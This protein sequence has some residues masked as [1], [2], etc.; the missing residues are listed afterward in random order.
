MIRAAALLLPLFLFAAPAI[1]D[2]PTVRTITT[3]GTA[4]IHVVPDEAMLRFTVHTFDADLPKSKKLNDAA[5]A[6]ILGFFRSNGI[7]AKD[8]Q[9]AAADS[10]AV[11][12]YR[13][14]NN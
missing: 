10:S 9:T 3:T 13:Q 8:I 11:Y 2:E 14:E 5:A 6:E 12:E 4:T 1:A 7:E